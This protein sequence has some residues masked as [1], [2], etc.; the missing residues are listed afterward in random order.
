VADESRMTDPLAPILKE[1]RLM[2]NEMATNKAEFNQKLVDRR[3]SVRPQKATQYQ[4]LDSMSRMHNRQLCSLHRAQL[5]AQ[6]LL[7]LWMKFHKRV[8]AVINPA[9]LE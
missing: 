8:E 6:R 7:S 3:K 5:L 4:P 9:V 2:R 1:L